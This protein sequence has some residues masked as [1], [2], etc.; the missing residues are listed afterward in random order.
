M[1]SSLGCGARRAAGS[2]FSCLALLVT[3]ALAGALAGCTTD[4]QQGVAAVQPRGATVAFESID[5]PPAGQFQTLVR[6]LNDEAQQRR[7][8]VLSRDAT[9]AYRVRGYLAATVAN[10]ETTISWV[11]DVF[12]RDEQRTL[13]IDGEE[14]AKR[15][16]KGTDPWN[17]ADD[18]ML[19]RIA[20]ASME[21]LADFLTSPDAV[22][23][24]AAPGATPV[25]F[26]G[27]SDTSP[28]AAGIYRIF[29]AEADP[30]AVPRKQPDAAAANSP[31]GRKATVQA[32]L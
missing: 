13:R 28:K 30:A 19:R 24:A 26:I 22:P 17:A 8:A 15:P 25:A 6:N 29:R 21:Q 27:A 16:G 12:D 32:S 2:A 4:G 11:W 9:S 1:R 7:V 23:V 10:G 14:H 5:G 3:I 20:S 18:A 31:A